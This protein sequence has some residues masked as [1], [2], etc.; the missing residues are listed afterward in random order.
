MDMDYQ[1][2]TKILTI[3]VSYTPWSDVY[4]CKSLTLLCH[5]RSAT[6]TDRYVVATWTMTDHGQSIVCYVLWSEG[7]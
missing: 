7:V 6:N 5:R 3:S 2:L 4:S 1:R